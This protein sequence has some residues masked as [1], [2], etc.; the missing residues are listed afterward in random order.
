MVMPRPPLATRTK[1][2]PSHALK[3]PGFMD[4]SPPSLISRSISSHAQVASCA[5]QHTRVQ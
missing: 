1:A 3:M 4:S 2:T 5:L